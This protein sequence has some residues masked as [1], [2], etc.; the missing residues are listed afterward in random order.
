MHRQPPFASGREEPALD[1]RVA[2]QVGRP[3]QGR[4]QVGWPVGQ[5]SRRGPARRRRPLDARRRGR[6]QRGRAIPPRL[7]RARWRIKVE[8]R[9]CGQHRRRVGRPAGR[10]V[11]ARLPLLDD[12]L[13]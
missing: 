13:P 2:R 6:W 3:R 4:R 12:I 1:G 5:R 9:S 7:E 10:V 8:D 11:D